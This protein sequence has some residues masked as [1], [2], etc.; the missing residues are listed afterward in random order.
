MVAEMVAPARR[1]AAFLAR[2]E[3]G[4]VPGECRALACELWL[5]CELWRDL[6]DTLAPVLGRCPA[7]AT[8]S[9]DP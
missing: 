6:P 8:K 7:S 4:S 1:C 3:D 9:V 2:S 5:T